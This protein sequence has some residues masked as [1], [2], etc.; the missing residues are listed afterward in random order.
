MAMS[1]TFSFANRC[2]QSKYAGAGFALAGSPSA[3]IIVTTCTGTD[4]YVIVV[5]SFFAHKTLL[6]VLHHLLTRLMSP[7][8]SI[9]TQWQEYAGLSCTL[10]WYTVL[11]LISRFNLLLSD[12]HIPA[13]RKQQQ[14][15]QQQHVTGT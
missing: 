1:V 11:V 9:L 14:L 2:S 10:N 15:Q 13:S 3:S 5:N 7:T 12:S 4:R 6:D 8:V